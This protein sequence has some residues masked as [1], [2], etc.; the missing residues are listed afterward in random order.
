VPLVQRSLLR[1][2]SIPAIVAGFVTILVGF[3]SSI[4]IVFE[5]ARALGANDAQ[6][7]S[8]VWALSVGMGLTTLLP[9]L[10]WRVPVVTAWSTAGAAMLITA[11]SGTTLAQATGAFIVSG[12]LIALSGFTGW[13]ERVM[14]RLPVGLASALLAGVL[15]RFG[16]DA[17]ASMQTRFDLVAPMALAWLLARRLMPRYAV[18]IALL[19]GVGI[20]AVGGD[21][22]TERLTLAIAS[23]V[24]VAPE[25]SVTAMIGVA[26]PLYVVTMASQNLPGVA[27]IRASG[28]PVPISPAIG[29]TGL[30]TAVLAPLGAYALNLAAITASIC[31][32]REAHEDPA[33]R[34]VAAVAAGVFFLLTGFF[35]ATVVSLLA[36]FPRELVLGIAGLALLGTI[37]NALAA[38]VVNESEREA[39]VVTFL[40]TASGLTLAG[41]GPAFWG[42]V[43]GVLT[44]A[45]LRVRRRGQPAA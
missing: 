18:V 1:D 4:V 35:G 29:F 27:A 43:G 10:F 45:A 12:V 5:A 31:L 13:F 9:S 21:L 26:L 34:Y 23:P 38:A 37:G 6:V 22:A 25:W 20:A 33:R 42:L 40:I 17:F 41:I 2:L 30:A 28:L 7:A 15:L 36:A 11:A 44:L 3:A 19:V 8:W 39:A 16:V 24:W 14:N 32:S